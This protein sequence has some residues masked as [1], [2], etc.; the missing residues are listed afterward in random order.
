MRQ[1]EGFIVLL[2]ISGYTNY[3]RSHNLRFVPVVGKHFR[4]T[5]EAH[6]EQVVT[7]LLEAL[8]NCT[9]DLLRAEKLEGDAVLLTAVPEDAEAFSPILVQRLREVF[10]A[11]HHR[12]GEIAFCTTC[13]CD[14]CSHMEAL[15]VKAIAHYGP[16]LIKEVAGF[17]EIAGQEVIRAHRLL[18][19]TVESDEY[20]M[21]TDAVAGLSG[22]G[23]S[24]SMSRHEEEDPSLGTTGVWVHFP[25]DHSLF[26]TVEG[27]TYVQR[28][29]QMWS[30]F[31]EEKSRDS[32]IPAAK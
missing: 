28:L 22:A 13:L 18:K 23:Q 5:S 21:L 32:L 12:L 15:R 8:I 1:V 11:F 30:Y 29:N 27:G 17:R 3:V 31:D 24:L 19:N 25:K 14:C 6:A 26:R 20:L 4:E 7:D 10:V 2:D 9:A 16:F